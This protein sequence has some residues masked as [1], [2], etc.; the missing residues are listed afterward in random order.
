MR[1]CGGAFRGI[2]ECVEGTPL[3]TPPG[4]GWGQRRECARGWAS[5]A[6]TSL[7]QLRVAW[8]GL[9]T[10]FL[11]ETAL[12]AKVALGRASLKRVR[13]LSHDMWS[14]GLLIGTCESTRPARSDAADPR[15]SWQTAPRS[16]RCPRRVLPAAAAAAAGAAEAAAAEAAAAAAVAA[17]GQRVGTGAG[18]AVAPVRVRTEPRRLLSP[19][20]FLRP[21]GEPS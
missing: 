3:C 18:A 2:P 21:A 7:D 8:R 11:C 14:R 12:Q 15:R 13:S 5:T 6:L 4:R 16:P 1:G 17:A 9:A 10:L 20:P 19:L